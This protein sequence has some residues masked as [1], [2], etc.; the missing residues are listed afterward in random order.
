[1]EQFK[2]RNKQTLIISYLCDIFFY[3]L[4]HS[5]L[6]CLIYGVFNSNAL[7]FFFLSVED[8]VLKFWGYYMKA[9]VKPLPTQRLKTLDI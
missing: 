8:N 3:N 6:N 7:C 9:M 4:R 5:T 2:I 1:M